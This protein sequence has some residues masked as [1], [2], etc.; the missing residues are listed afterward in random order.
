MKGKFIVIYGIN[1]I[2]K[3][4]QVRLL[5]RHL[6]KKGKAVEYVKYPVYS[7]KPS[8]VFIDEYLRRK[9]HQTISP[10]ELQT[11]YALNRMQFEYRL[12]RWLNLGVCVVAEDYKGTGIAWGAATGVNL[13]W[14]EQLNKKQLNPDISILIDGERFL[15]SKEKDHKFEQDDDLTQTCRIIHRKLAKKYH[16][17]I[18]DANQSI[19]KVH[20]DIVKLLV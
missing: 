11:W 2:G 19:E 18:V 4:T 13:E 6:R 17:H 16:W 10:E 8:G 7:I 3:T 12:K 9:K 5:V 15:N 20:G 1:N 14:L